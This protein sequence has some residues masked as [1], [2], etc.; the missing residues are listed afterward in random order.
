MATR[1]IV[2]FH[3]DV[4]CDVCGRRLLRGEQ[5][6]IF[7]GGGHRRTVCELC[8]PRAAHE[9]WLREADGPS[10][11]PR[12]SRPRPGRSIL[13]RLRQSRR[14]TAASVDLQS[15]SPGSEQGASDREDG[16]LYDFLD[17]T[18]SE[19]R[20]PL[21]RDELEALSGSGARPRLASRDAPEPEWERD[22]LQST[23]EADAAHLP[24]V[25]L[26]ATDSNGLPLTESTLPSSAAKVIRAL[27]VFNTGEHPRRVAGV[28]RSLGPPSVKANPVGESPGVVSIVVAWELCWYRYDVDLGDEL[29]G[30]TLVA[31]G[32]ELGE[33]AHEDRVANAGA[34][35]RGE[36]ALLR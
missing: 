6:D 13:S 22:E 21:L 29:A 35:E 19:A 31:Q 8:A 36:L 30:A 3:P 15:G 7:L 27:D 1:T 33:L 2:T 26:P 34:N 10:L 14:T 4:E 32:M 11:A 5:P 16:G 28:A 24:A 20:P 12:S 25:E 23:G 9:G 18:S 17:S